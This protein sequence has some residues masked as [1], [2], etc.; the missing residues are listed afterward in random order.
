ML[1]YVNLSAKISVVLLQI[2]HGCVEVD[3]FNPVPKVVYAMDG[4][5]RCLV[6]SDVERTL[7]HKLRTVE[8][9]RRVEISPQGIRSSVD[10]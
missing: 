6:N 7:Q 4:L 3:L 2:L 10:K 1:R 9:R 5:L 8:A